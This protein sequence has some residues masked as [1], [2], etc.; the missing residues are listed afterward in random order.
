MGLIGIQAIISQTRNNAGQ[1]SPLRWTCEVIGGAAGSSV[2]F[3]TAW[4]LRSSQLHLCSRPLIVLGYFLLPALPPFL[5]SV[6]Y[7]VSFPVPLFFFF[8]CD[9]AR[10]LLL[11]GLSWLAYVLSS[12]ACGSTIFP[13]TPSPSSSVVDK[14]NT[15]MPTK[16]MTSMVVS[17]TH[18]QEHHSTL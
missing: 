10:W 17:L 14:L 1:Q 16:V 9:G 13:G 11:A 4:L 5:V 2:V 12:C 15:A 7:N 3:N 18:V 8:Q 6:R